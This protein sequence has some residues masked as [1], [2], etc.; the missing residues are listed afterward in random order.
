MVFLAKNITFNRKKI[1][2]GNSLVLGP[3]KRLILET[4]ASLCFRHYSQEMISW[5]I[6]PKRK[7]I[8]E[9]ALFV[10]TMDLLRENADQCW[11]KQSTAFFIW[12]IGNCLT[13][14]LWWWFQVD[15]TW[16]PSKS[17][18]IF[19]WKSGNASVAPLVLHGFVGGDHNLPSG[20]PYAHLPCLFYIKKHLLAVSTA[21]SVV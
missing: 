13:C 21:N 2:S 7:P 15:T 16:A 9:G 12:S 20:D 8:K 4:L 5:S 3:L 10:S 6:R 11:N 1:P 18:S 19:T 17:T 14:Y